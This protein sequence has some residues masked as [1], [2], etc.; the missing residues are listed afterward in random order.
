MFNS[1]TLSPTLKTSRKMCLYHHCEYHCQVG[2]LS[3]L[4]PGSDD[5]LSSWNSDQPMTM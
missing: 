2:F 1:T 4:D 5:A 3:F